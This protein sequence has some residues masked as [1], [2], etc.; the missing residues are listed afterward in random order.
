MR[1]NVALWNYCSGD[2]SGNMNSCAHPTAAFNWANT[3]DISNMLQSQANSRLVSGLFLA[4]FILFFI[5]CGWS[6]LLWLMSI[7][8][9]CFR[10]RLFGYSMS[11]LVLINFFIML[12]AL[13]LAL[14]LIISGVKLVTANQGWSAYAGNSLWITIGAVISLL[15]ST[16]FYCCGSAGGGGGRN[17]RRVKHDDK[18]NY[19]DYAN[20]LPYSTNQ[21]HY[22]GSQAG[23]AD[24]HHDQQQAP[25]TLQQPYQA[26][27]P[28]VGQQGL[29]TGVDSPHPDA[30]QHQDQYTVP[31]GYQ[32]PTLQPANLPRQN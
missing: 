25:E 15:L 26:A 5:A 23:Y 14:V 20:F 12:A 13:I 4:M 17:R 30:A 8:I 31:R 28:S 10:R 16:M 1:Y 27:T 24:D 2:L 21:P 18:E 32:T 7:P 11:I 9:C 3:P 6:F 22:G 29:S 19:N